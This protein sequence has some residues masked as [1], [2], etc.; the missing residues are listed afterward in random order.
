MYYLLKT[1]VYKLFV[2]HY[3]KSTGECNER[4]IDMSLPKASYKLKH[5]MGITVEN[6]STR[7]KSAS[8]HWYDAKLCKLR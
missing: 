7:S 1:S 3:L 2:S 4:N 8:Q 5:T 6:R